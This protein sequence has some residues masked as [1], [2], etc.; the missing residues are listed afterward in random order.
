MSDKAALEAAERAA[1][2]EVIASARRF[3]DTA[4]EFW[5]EYPLAVGEAL[6]HLDGAIGDLSVIR[7][8]DALREALKEPACYRLVKVSDEQAQE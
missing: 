8:A 5:P 7:E 3:L 6:D 2:E 4:A 1:M